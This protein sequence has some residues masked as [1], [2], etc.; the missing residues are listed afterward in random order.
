MRIGI[1]TYH[2]SDN[3]GALFQAYALRKWFL[4]RGCEARFVNYHPCYVEEGGAFERIYSPR[5]W[6]KN[7]TVIY[8]RLMF[9]RSQLLGSRERKKAFENFRREH[10]G[11]VVSRRLNARELEPEIRDLDALVCGSDQIWNPSI[12]RGLDPVYFLDIPGSTG[13]RKFAYAPSFGRTEI[14]DHY[15]NELTGLLAG[16]DGVSVRERSGLN[17]LAKAGCKTATVVPDPTILLGTFDELL[18]GREG[19][20]G[21]VFCYALRTDAIIRDVAVSA[22]QQI[23][24]QLIS[25]RSLHKRWRDIGQGVVCGPVEWLRML[26]RAEMVV[27]NSFH[28]IAL[29]VVLNRPFIAV[30]IHGKKSSLNAR[31][32]N[33][34]ESVGLL[35]R[36][37]SNVDRVRINALINTPID[38]FEVNRKLC[39]IREEGENY[40]GSQLRHASKKESPRN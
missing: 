6:R 2:F 30:S 28:G 13:Q 4:D 21:S 19:A 15:I 14:E 20:E 31:A 35:D 12:E 16:L 17:I 18:G 11:L 22:S 38:W 8:K 39:G 5:N 3:Y 27:S 33:L 9:L 1:L 7:V 10:L 29:S 34:L 23:G 26:H 36:F 24:G 32:F 37:L 40:L 25:P